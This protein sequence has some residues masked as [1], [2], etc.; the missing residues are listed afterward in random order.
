MRIVSPLLKKVV[1][2]ALSRAGVFHHTSGAGLAVVTYHGV[3]PEGYEPVDD[4]LDGNLVRPDMLRLQL[5]RLRTHYQVIS[6]QD[7][8]AWR[9]GRGQLPERAVL[10]TC[11][12]GLLNCLTDM[13]PVLEEERVS[14]LFLVTSASSGAARTAL[15][16]EQLFRALLATP[17]GTLAM[18]AEGIRVQAEIRSRRE[19]R[20]LWWDLVQRLSGL[21]A[22]RRAAFLSAF[23]AQLGSRP[24]RDLED[25]KS[26]FCR[27][28][29]L[30]NALELRRLLA[31]GMTVGGHTLSHP[32]LSHQ[33][34]EM[35]YQEIAQNRLLLESSLGEKIWAFAYPFGNPQ[36]VSPQVLAM[37]ERAGYEVAFLNFGGGLGS[38]LLPYALPRV[39]VTAE[40]SLAEFE[41]HVS[42]FY[43]RLQRGTGAGIQPRGVAQSLAS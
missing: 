26:A 21:D 13:L 30:L 32:L 10:V 15:W 28:Y 14:C 19:R 9:R 20:G 34:E 40:M 11:D 3:V 38:L 43:L 17:D 23:E 33:S 25:E 24:M 39:H 1:Y 6:P 2:P 12:D 36:A 41:A 4:A 16:Y 7:V 42:G 22:G 27:R 5:K 31:A 8:L 18:G 35:A 37:P 29:G